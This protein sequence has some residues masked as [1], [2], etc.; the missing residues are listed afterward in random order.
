MKS[1]LCLWEMGRG[2]ARVILTAEQRIEAPN[3]SPCG[4]YLLVNGGGALFRVPLDAPALVP[5]DLAGLT[6]VNNDHGIAPDGQSYAVSSH[7]RGLGA[8]IYLVPA[9]GGVPRLISPA[10]HSWWHG[11]SP[12][13]KTMVY[14][15]VRG[16][17]RDVDLCAL[18]LAGGEERR[19]TL[20]GCHHDGPDYAADGARIYYNCDRQGHAQIWVMGAD[21]CG[22]QRLFSDQA[23]NWFPHPSPCGRHLIWLAYPPG[24]QGHPADVPVAIG[25]AGPDGQNREVLLEMIGGQGTMNVPNW[26][27]DGSA[28]AFVRYDLP[29]GVI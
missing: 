10:A 11:W 12:D 28:F 15:A 7:H 19:L 14:A 5:V 6:R 22:Q 9:A 4:R 25:R 26:A 8:E 17:G 13:G 27:P 21:G 24:T 29:E 23:V 3:W 1:A 16:G 20:G 18:T 2:A